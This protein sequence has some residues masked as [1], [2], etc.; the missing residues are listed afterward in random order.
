MELLLSIPALVKV[1]GT[2]SLIL[3]LNVLTRNPMAAIAAGALVLGLWSGQPLSA[4]GRIAWAR[5]SSLDN[6]LPMPGS[7]LF[8][9]CNFSYT[10]L[11]G[12]KLIKGN[13]GGYDGD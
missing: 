1:L 13:R 9:E 5:F 3:I 7:V 6:L 8:H 4:V 10:G 12:K 11:K 2:L